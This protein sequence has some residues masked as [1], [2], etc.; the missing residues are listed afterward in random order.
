[1]VKASEWRK[2]F[3]EHF[4]VLKREAMVRAV[5]GITSLT[6]EECLEKFDRGTPEHGDEV[7]KN[8]NIDAGFREEIINSL[9]YNAY[10][11]HFRCLDE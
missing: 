5:T 7:G 11:L 10:M 6:L 2:I 1:M 4:D 9:N 3:E 8:L